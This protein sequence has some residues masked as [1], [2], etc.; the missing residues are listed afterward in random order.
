M[1]K[2]EEVDNELD[3]ILAHSTAMFASLVHYGEMHC[4]FRSRGMD[5]KKWKK[6][7]SLYQNT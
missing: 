3:G 2:D 7:H 4:T 1:V 5:W 6:M